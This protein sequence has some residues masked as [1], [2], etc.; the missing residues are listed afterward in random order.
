MA[1]QEATEP[2]VQLAQS[3]NWKWWMVGQKKRVFLQ[4]SEPY[5]FYRI[6]NVT[7]YYENCEIQIQYLDLIID[8]YNRE[9]P[10][11]EYT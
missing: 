3:D 2:W 1:K 7:S 11:L 9:I 6:E 4:N 5:Q 10:A 8:N